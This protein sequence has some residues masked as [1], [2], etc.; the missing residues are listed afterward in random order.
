MLQLQQKSLMQ[1]APPASVNPTDWV[2]TVLGMRSISSGNSLCFL[3]KWYFLLRLW[4]FPMM[5]FVHSQ[6]HPWLPST[7][8]WHGQIL[9][10]LGLA[11]PCQ[12]SELPGQ[13]QMLSEVNK[14]E[15]RDILQHTYMLPFSIPRNRHHYTSIPPSLQHYT[16]SSHHHTQELRDENSSHSL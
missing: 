4:E 1:T 5:Y 11:Q 6:C 13:C 9:S 14:A 12:N 2:F 10:A 15:T 8:G 16:P 3:L 7:V